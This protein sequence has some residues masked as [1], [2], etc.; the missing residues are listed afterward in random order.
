MLSG[1]SLHGFCP[2]TRKGGPQAEDSLR[3]R[4]WQRPSVPF[5]RDMEVTAH[6]HVLV[7]GIRTEKLAWQAGGTPAVLGHRGQ[8]HTNIPTRTLSPTASP[9]HSSR[10]LRGGREGT[11]T[12]E[13]PTQ[14]VGDLHLGGGGWGLH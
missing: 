4:W 10:S 13:S 12:G 6:S 3:D 11:L 14:K 9:P 5:L 8:I 2:N 1:S 7:R